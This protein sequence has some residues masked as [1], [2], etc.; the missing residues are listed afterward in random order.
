M[1]IDIKE[2]IINLKSLAEEKSL[3]EEV[4]HD[5]IEQALAAALAP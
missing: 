5:I 4:I 2:L 3:P 1:E